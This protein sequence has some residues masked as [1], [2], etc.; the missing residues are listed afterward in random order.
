M[1]EGI[2]SD[3]SIPFTTPTPLPKSPDTRSNLTSSPP[4]FTAWRPISG[5]AAGAGTPAR[6]PGCIGW[7]WRAFWAYIAPA[8][9]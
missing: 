7:G 6:Q 1:A 2:S 9:A 3:C 8:P 5:G 4:M